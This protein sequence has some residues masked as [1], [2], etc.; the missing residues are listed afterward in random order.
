MLPGDLLDMA[1]GM[2]EQSPLGSCVQRVLAD[3]EDNLQDL[4]HLYISD[5]LYFTF[6]LRPPEHQVRG[7]ARWFWYNTYT[8]TPGEK[9]CQMVLVK[10]NAMLVRPTLCYLFCHLTNNVC[11]P[12]AVCNSCV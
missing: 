3:S 10:V 9:L 6:P 12:E 1:G 4:F 5:L 8:T 7:C 11:L 2:V